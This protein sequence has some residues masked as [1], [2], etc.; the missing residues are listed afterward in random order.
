MAGIRRRFIGFGVAIFVTTHCSSLAGAET[1]RQHVDPD[2]SRVE[3]TVYSELTTI[4][5]AVRRY[6][7]T[8]TLDTEEFTRSSIAAVVDPAAIEIEADS[9]LAGLNSLL[10]KIPPRP[11]TFKSSAIVPAGKNRFTVVGT[12]AQGNEKRTIEVPLTVDRTGKKRTRILLKLKGKLGGVVQPLPIPIEPGAS[13]GEVNAV[14][15][16]R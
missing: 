14:L 15:V 10:Q 2:G 4:S 11:I 9:P 1:V 7:G 6:E 3:F 8:L 12:V 13:T 16:F 5:G